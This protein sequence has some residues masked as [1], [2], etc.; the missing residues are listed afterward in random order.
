MLCIKE[1]NMGIST[2]ITPEFCFAL[3]WLVTGQVVRNPT[4]WY[5]LRPA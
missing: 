1:Y 2:V 5:L 4:A 3:D